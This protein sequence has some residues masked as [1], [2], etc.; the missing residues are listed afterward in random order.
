M[1]A[2]SVILD[3]SAF[4]AAVGIDDAGRATVA[5][6]SGSRAIKVARGVP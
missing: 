5:W 3:A 6:A 4:G 2:M 1:F